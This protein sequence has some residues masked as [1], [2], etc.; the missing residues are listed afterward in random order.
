[1]IRVDAFREIEGPWFR[2]IDAENG[3]VDEGMYFY[4]KLIEKYKSNSASS[5]KGEGSPH[6]P[7][8]IDGATLCEHHDVNTGAVHVLPKGT[9]P[10]RDHAGA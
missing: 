9:L 5:F 6:W 4:A 8:W 3:G 2:R 1:M 7:I 10:W